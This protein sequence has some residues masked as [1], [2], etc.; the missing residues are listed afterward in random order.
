MLLEEFDEMALC[1]KT[2]INKGMKRCN[3]F[4]LVLIYWNMMHCVEKTHCRDIQQTVIPCTLCADQ[5]RLSMPFGRIKIP[6]YEIR[7]WGLFA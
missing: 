1:G 6:L 3:L 5:P 7:H 4:L 2:P